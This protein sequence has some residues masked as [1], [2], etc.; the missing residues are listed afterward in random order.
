MNVGGPKP[1]RRVP[2]FVVGKAVSEAASLSDIK[3]PPLVLVSNP[4]KDVDTSYC[5]RVFFDLCAQN[6]DDWRAV[7]PVLAARCAAN[8]TDSD[9]FVSQSMASCVWR[10][11]LNQQ[12]F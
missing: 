2:V 3:R 7:L 8:P 10:D 11:S 12:R 4:C 5:R 1:N 6:A 9:V